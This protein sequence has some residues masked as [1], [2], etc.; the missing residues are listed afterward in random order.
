MLAFIV[1]CSWS[2]MLCATAVRL[3][4]VVHVSC[5]WFFGSYLVLSAYDRR[6]PLLYTHTQPQILTLSVISSLPSEALPRV[7]RMDPLPRVPLVRI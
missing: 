3:R 7:I 2:R 5:F 1:G 4:T 6:P